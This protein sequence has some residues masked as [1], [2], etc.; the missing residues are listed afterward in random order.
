MDSTNIS[1]PLSQLPLSGDALSDV[2]VSLPFPAHLKDAKTGRYCISNKFQAEYTGF[3]SKEDIVGLTASDIW[4]HERIH[5]R[6]RGGSI[7]LT[8]ENEK[9]S[10]ELEQQAI[11]DKCA[12]T[13]K[14]SVLLPDGCIYRELLQKLPIF[15][16][17]GK[18]LAIFTSSQDLTPETDLSY[19]FHLYNQYYPKKEA[20]QYLL[21][22]FKVDG[23]F[24]VVPTYSEALVLL[25]MCRDHSYKLTGK[26]LN[27]NPRTI[28]VHTRNL[29]GKLKNISVH[30]LLAKMR[31]GHRKKFC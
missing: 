18:L 6:K 7:P 15:S 11:K 20:V 5:I 8:Y 13:L 16:Q 2:V 25:S 12:V 27:I 17:A 23:Y 10:F 24:S 21:K 1:S 19:L 4:A 29:R 30:E 9:S 26:F 3:K 14:T 22:Y 28:E 31:N